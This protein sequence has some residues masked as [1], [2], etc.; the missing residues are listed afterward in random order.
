MPDLNWN[1]GYWGGEYHWSQA[2]DEWSAFWN[3]SEAQWYG[4]LFPRLHR[5]LPASRML[6]IAVGHGRWTRFLLPRSE[7]FVGIDLNANC[8]EACR[9]RFGSSEK[10]RFEV[11]DGMSLASANG[12]FNFVF[13]FDS[14]VHAEYEVFER[15]IPQIIERLSADGAAFLHHSNLG[16][17]T[18]FTGNTHMRAATVSGDRIAALIDACGGEVLVQE[19][20]DWGKSTSLDCFTTFARRGAFKSESIGIK[21][22]NLE[23]MKEA[24]I[25]SSYQS[26]YSRIEKVG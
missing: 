13:S 1:S 24:S 14:L 22:Q 5:F 8:I 21:L 25:V 20:V 11:N 3:G 2:G 9:K 19:I 16:A 23:F 26:H 4:A 10:T 17:L 6:E 7:S 15:Y 18:S 12:P